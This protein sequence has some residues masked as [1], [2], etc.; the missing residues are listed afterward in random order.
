MK[1]GASLLSVMIRGLYHQ[2]MNT[3]LANRWQQ[4]T[5]PF[6]GPVL[7]AG[8]GMTENALLTTVRLSRDLLRDAYGQRG[9]YAN[10]DW[11]DHDG[12]ITPERIV[13]WTETTSWTHDV[14]GLRRSCSDDWRVRMLLFP[15]DF[16]FCMRYWLDGE[17]EC[18]FDLCAERAMLE[19]IASSL[20]S[21]GVAVS[22]EQSAKDYLDRRWAG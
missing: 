8:D 21:E 17:D 9:L 1:S 13:S 2:T 19:R 22:I 10:E 7:V 4:G 5:R 20:Q 11:H 6:D 18:C 3:E 14:E 16:T 15:D 12:I